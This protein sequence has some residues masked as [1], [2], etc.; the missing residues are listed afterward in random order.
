MYRQG[1]CGRLISHLHCQSIVV[2]FHIRDGLIALII[3]TMIL[4][5]TIIKCSRMAGN[6]FLFTYMRCLLP[7]RRRYLSMLI[8]QG[9][10]ALPSQSRFLPHLFGLQRIFDLVFVFRCLSDTLELDSAGAAIFARYL[11]LPCAGS[12]F[13]A[14]EPA[15]R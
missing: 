1:F 11:C 9:T 6:R 7:K 2:G 4:Y 5:M 14:S 10:K 8:T 13:Q 3:D 15:C 12:S